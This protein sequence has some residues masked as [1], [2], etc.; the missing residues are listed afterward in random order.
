MPHSGAYELKSTRERSLPFAALATHQRH[1]LRQAKQGVLVYKIPDSGFQNPFD[2]F[3]LA[4]VPA[5]VVVF[6]YTHGKKEFV[7]I[8]ID[9]WIAEDESSTRRSLTEERAKEI[10]TTYSLG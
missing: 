2:C 6:F 1:A 4:Q 5:F 9:A 3:T 8:D 7:M 10:G